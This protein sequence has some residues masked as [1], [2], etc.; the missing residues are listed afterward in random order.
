[1]HELRSRTQVK[2]ARLVVIVGYEIC[3]AV[4]GCAEFTEKEISFFEQ[5]SFQD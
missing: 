5:F 4:S 3:T 1:M 2:L